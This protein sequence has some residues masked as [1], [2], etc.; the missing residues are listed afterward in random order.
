MNILLV[1][2]N[3]KSKY[4][5][6]GLMKIAQYH[7]Q[8]SDHVEFVKGI[9]VE[10]R[11]KYEWDRVYISSLFT[12]DWKLTLKAIKYYRFC[13]APPISENLVI[14]GVLATILS[15]DVLADVNCRV[16]K[17]LLDKKGKLGYE[18]DNIIDTLLPD[19]EILNE[20]DYKYPASNAYITYATR[21]CIRRCKFC[22]V[23]RIE[24]EFKH[25]LSICDEIEEID[26]RY[27]PKKDLLLL[28]NNVLASDNFKDII[29]DIKKAGFEKGAKYSYTGKWGQKVSARRVVDFNQGLDLRLLDDEKMALLSEIAINPLRIAFDDISYTDSYVSKIHIAAKY[30]LKYLSNYILYNFKDRPEDF[31]ERLKINVQLNEELGLSIFSFPMRYIDLHSKDRHATTPG[32]LGE[33]WNIKYLRAIQCILVKTRG[34]VGTKLD[35]FEAAFGTSLDEYRKILLMPEDYIVNRRSHERDGSTEQWW[36]KYHDLGTQE[37]D[38]FESIVFSNNLRDIEY[39]SLSS[40]IRRL[41]DHYLVRDKYNHEGQ[42]QLELQLV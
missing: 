36:Q 3:Y 39:G 23:H 8:K 25:Y 10:K 14:G 30:G 4:P 12:Y 40:S 37:K 31:Y 27:G 38:I 24:P 26:K 16:V 18:D 32:N 15:K 35:Y 29:A 21:G 6:L 41:L 28:D 34:I 13:V 33:H 42:N 20:T 9:S 22:A 7:K 5:P 11:D 2:P 17:G 1:E 19:Y